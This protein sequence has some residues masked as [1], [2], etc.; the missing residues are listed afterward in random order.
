MSFTE[1]CHASLQI[2]YRK[3]LVDSAQQSFGAVQGWVHIGALGYS[4]LVRLQFQSNGD[5]LV[6]GVQ[7]EQL[8]VRKTIQNSLSWEIF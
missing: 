7:W 4:C 3:R 5:Y 1:Y 8:E 2:Q 6:M